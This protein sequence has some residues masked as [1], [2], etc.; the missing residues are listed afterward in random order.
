MAYGHVDCFG[1]DDSEEEG[2]GPVE[3]VSVRGKT[4]KFKDDKLYDPEKGA[5]SLA[6]VASQFSSF[7]HDVREELDK[8]DPAPAARSS[9]SRAE[10]LQSNSMASQPSS[11]EGKVVTNSNNLE[12]ERQEP[13]LPACPSR[14]P[15]S[16]CGGENTPKSAEEPVVRPKIRNLASPNCVKPKIF[17]DTDDDDDR[18]TQLSWQLSSR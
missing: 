8:L 9:A 10:F 17:F 1:A 14:A 6:G 15:V 11:A 7:N 3:R 2:A 12:R 4:G 13:N 5:R 18:I 16:I